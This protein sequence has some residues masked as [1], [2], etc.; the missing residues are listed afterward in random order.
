MGFFKLTKVSEEVDTPSSLEL[1][2]SVEEYC[3]SKF[4]LPCSTDF[5]SN[6]LE[7]D[8]GQQSNRDVTEFLRTGDQIHCKECD[9]ILTGGGQVRVVRPTSGSGSKTDKTDKCKANRSSP[10]DNSN[11]QSSV[12]STSS[13]SIFNTISNSL[14]LHSAAHSNPASIYSNQYSLTKTSRHKHHT[15]EKS[16][17]VSSSKKDEPNDLSICVLHKPPPAYQQSDL[18]ELHFTTTTISVH[19][20]NSQ[21]SDKQM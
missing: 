20:A 15:K 14:A 9:F 10:V 2:D 13:Y 3:H 4:Y 16:S 5:N 8:Q 21:K 7:N 18:A 12:S 1:I 17:S 11:Q 19:Q 6:L